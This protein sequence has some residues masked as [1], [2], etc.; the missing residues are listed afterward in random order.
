MKLAGFWT[1]QSMWGWVVLLPITVAQVRR[2]SVACG[3]C[4]PQP[5]LTGCFA[6]SCGRRYDTYPH[7]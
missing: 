1:A 5:V 7:M 3:G 2:T 4:F 6:A